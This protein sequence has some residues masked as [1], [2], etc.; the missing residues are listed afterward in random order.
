M[1]EQKSSGMHHQLNKTEE[2]I[3]QLAMPFLAVR[4]NEVHT[5]AAITFALRLL[6][7]EEGD[8]D[9]VIPAAILHDVG[10]SSLPEHL[11]SRAWGP[12]KET[13]ITRIHEQE[14][15]R[16]A[17]AILEEVG[18]DA[19]K[20]AE[21]LE[22]IDGH[23]TRPEALSAN[24]RIVRDADKLTRYAKDLESWSPTFCSTTEEAA[25]RLERSVDNWF[26]LA[27]SKEIAR[28]ELKQRRL[29][30]RQGA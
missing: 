20:A 30:A 22:I 10:Y 8:R 1:A 5:R 16:I 15:A 24:D 18:Y 23:D 28:Q 9:I 12:R 27:V 17:A 2:K 11:M 25:A 21:I 19:F 14:G 13:A 6:E 7:T 4:D 29:E 26:F 3:F